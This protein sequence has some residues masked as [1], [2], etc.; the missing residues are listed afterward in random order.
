M[1]L[2]ALLGVLIATVAS[3]LAVDDSLDRFGRQDLQLSARHTAG[4]AAVLYADDP[5]GWTPEK[6]ATLARLERLNGHTVVVRDPS[7]R[8]VEGS[9]PRPA[10]DSAT[11][12]VRVA[13]QQVGTISLGHPAG[14]FLRLEQDEDLAGELHG[15]LKQLMILGGLLAGVVAL[16]VAIG[17]AM[18]V[19]RPI[20]RL[21]E[22]AERIE[23]GNLDQPAGSPGGSAEFDQLGRTL[24]RLAATLKRQEEVRRE[25]VSDLAHELRTPVTGLRGRIEAAQDGAMRDMP[26]VL[27]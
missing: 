3:V 9:P 7:G 27:A 15:E 23:A 8:V 18:A 2:V 5:H 21:R 6:A 17:S 12:P 10:E 25:T 14:G 16:V 1:I 19:A 4:V 22:A 26:S 11:E 20:R 13:G 24:D